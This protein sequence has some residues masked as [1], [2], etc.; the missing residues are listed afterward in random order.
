MVYEEMAELKDVVELLKK[1]DAFSERLEKVQP[2]SILYSNFSKKQSTAKG[3]IGPI[4]NRFAIFLKDHEY[5]LEVHKESWAAASEGLRLY[6][7]L[8]ELW[9][10]PAEG[11]DKESSEYRKVI[12]HDIEDFKILVSKF[13]VNL[14]KAEDLVELV[15]A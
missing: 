3:R 10:V 14:E 4:P 2:D 8:H 11:F 15:G 1:S 5:F 12:K 13:G 9:H 6:I 7:I